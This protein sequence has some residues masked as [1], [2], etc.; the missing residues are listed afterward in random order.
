MQ[1]SQDH[2]FKAFPCPDQ[3][4]QSTRSL[5]SC[6]RK[7]EPPMFFFGAWSP[8]GIFLQRLCDVHGMSKRARYGMAR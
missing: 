4:C 7:V 3:I 2:P 5:F 1:Y 6:K 8:Q